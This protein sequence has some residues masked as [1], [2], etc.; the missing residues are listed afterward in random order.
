MKMLKW[1]TNSEKSLESDEH[2][3]ENGATDERKCE[4]IWKKASNWIFPGSIMTINRFIRYVRQN[5]FNRNNYKRASICYCQVSQIKV[6]DSSHPFY[7]INDK[8]EPEIVEEPKCGDNRQSNGY[9][10]F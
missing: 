3:Q 6:N 8:Q 2:Y 5:I 10:K 9:E 7:A 4:S 1:V